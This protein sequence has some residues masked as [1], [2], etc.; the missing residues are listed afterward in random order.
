MLLDGVLADIHRHVFGRHLPTSTCMSVSRA[1]IRQR[2][3]RFCQRIFFMM[4]VENAKLAP[5]T[6]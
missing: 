5:T 6:G 1:Q 3:F 4:N 2:A